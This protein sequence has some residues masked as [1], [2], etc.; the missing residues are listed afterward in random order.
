MDELKSR[1]VFQGENV[2]FVEKEETRHG[3]GESWKQGGSISVRRNIFP[4]IFQGN[5]TLANRVPVCRRCLGGS[6]FSG[7][8]RL[9][10]GQHGRWQ[11]RSQGQS[12][13]FDELHRDSRGSSCPWLY[14]QVRRLSNR[15][16]ETRRRRRIN[17]AC[18]RILYTARCRSLNA[19]LP[20]F[21]LSTKTSVYAEIRELAA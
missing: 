3:G 20:N 14:P 11:M 13:P 12:K 5:A 2:K 19:G 4:V 10:F 1:L 9:R 18:T 16:I 17:S 6:S 8:L 21:C 15:Y 7:V